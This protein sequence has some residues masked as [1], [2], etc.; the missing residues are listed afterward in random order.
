[1]ERLVEVVE[2]RSTGFIAVRIR[3]TSAS[4]RLV[5][6]APRTPLFAARPDWVQQVGRS[7]VSAGAH[8]ILPD[9]KRVDEWSTAAAVRRV[10]GFV[11]VMVE[12][13]VVGRMRRGRASAAVRITARCSRRSVRPALARASAEAKAW[14]SL[15]GVTVGLTARG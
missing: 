1:V 14:A 9:W 3:S 6:C 15:V 5:G 11:E 12:R 8:S 4:R 2:V 13:F 10:G 7:P